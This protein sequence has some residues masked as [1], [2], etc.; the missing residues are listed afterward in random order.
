MNLRISEM[1]FGTNLKEW[2]VKFYYF[3]L[4]YNEKWSVNVFWVL[5]LSYCFK[6]A[7]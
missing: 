4:Y 5:I 6:T 1:P 2:F 7:R 3:N